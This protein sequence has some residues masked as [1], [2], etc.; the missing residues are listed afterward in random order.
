MENTKE[1]LIPETAM[2]KLIAT[3]VSET[4][5]AKNEPKAFSLKVAN[6]L[7]SLPGSQW[8]LADDGYSWNGKDLAVKADEDKEKAASKK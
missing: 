3:D 6:R 8:K 1:N 5:G 7:L 4:D 2:I